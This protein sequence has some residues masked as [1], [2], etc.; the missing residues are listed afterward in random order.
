MT[1][2]A[3]EVPGYKTTRNI[4]VVRGLTVRSRSCPMTVAALLAT[5][6]GGKNTAF[7]TLCERSRQQ[8]FELM[9]IHAQELGANAVIGIHYDASEVVGGVMEVFAYG[10]AVFVEKREE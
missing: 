4:G 3:F 5:C 9:L 10:T 7:Q 6:F 1:T 8:A 2:T